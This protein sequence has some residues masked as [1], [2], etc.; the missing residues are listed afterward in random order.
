MNS[1]L[2]L[3]NSN[4]VSLAINSI[5]QFF[6]LEKCQNAVQHVKQTQSSKMYVKSVNTYR[7]ITF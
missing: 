4:E 3:V 5:N 6:I 2:C 7:Y 1:T